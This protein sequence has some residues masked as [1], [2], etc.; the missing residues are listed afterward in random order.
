MHKALSKFILIKKNTQKL[1]LA[2][3]LFIELMANYKISSFARGENYETRIKMN[4][5]YSK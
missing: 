2:S 4:T 5:W 1:P 3:F